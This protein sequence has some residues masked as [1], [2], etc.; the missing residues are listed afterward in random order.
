MNEI[1]NICNDLGLPIG[2]NFTQDWAYELSDEYRTEEWLDKYITAYLNN[3]YSVSSKN[4]LMTLCLDVTN[5]LLSTGTSVIN[6][7]IIKVLNTLIDN[8]QQHVD[9]I[10]YWSLDDEPLEDCFALTPEIRKLKKY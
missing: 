5:D 4:E 1:N 10:N 3:G 2:D 9:L 8:Y 7:T 6:A